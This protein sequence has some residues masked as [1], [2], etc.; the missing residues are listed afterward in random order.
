M[1]IFYF[2]SWH[3][4]VVCFSNY[5]ALKRQTTA[6]NQKKKVLVSNEVAFRC[7][8]VIK[9]HETIRLAQ[10]V[11]VMQLYVTVNVQHL[12]ETWLFRTQSYFKLELRR[13]LLVEIV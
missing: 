12:T 7:R 10:C 6:L 13:C 3:S 5:N 11:G 4:S 9:P 2:I 8:T 1:F